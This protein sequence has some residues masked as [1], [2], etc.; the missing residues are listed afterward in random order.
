MS[1]SPST[2]AS[3]VGPKDVIVARS[4][5]PVPSPPSARYS[6]GKPVAVHCWPTDAA[7][8]VTLGSSAPGVDSPDRSP[9]MSAANTGTP[10]GGELLGHQLER[11]GLAGPGGPGDQAVPVEHPQRDPHVYVGE[12]VGV[13]HQP[14]QLERG[15]LEGVAGG[16]LGRVRVRGR[17]RR[18][19]H[20]P[21]L[22]ASGGLYAVQRDL[23]ARG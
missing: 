4:G 12:G 16:D 10:C 13:Q 9:L 14:A 2:F 21:T 5:T 11:L 8:A 1:L 23:Q 3:R 19:A 18:V 17:G 7:R 15:T 6:T 20:A 22:A